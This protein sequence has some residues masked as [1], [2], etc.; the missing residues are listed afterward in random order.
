[1]KVELS[2]RPKNP[3]IIE[4]FP[5]FG[6]VGN[7]STEF[8][9][10]HLHAEQ[11]GSIKLEESS[12]MIA[13][14]SG[15]V[16][17]PIG[18]FYDKENNIVI[19]HVIASAQGIEWKMAEIISKLAEDLQARE[20]IC[21]EGVVGGE[22]GSSRSFYFSNKKSS[23]KK[24]EEIK[25]D[26]LK[27]GIVVGVTGALLLEKDLP[28]SSIF[29]ETHSAMPDSKAAA[30]AIEVLD[31]YLGLNVDY[32]PLLKQAQEFENKLKTLMAQKNTVADAQEKKRMSYIS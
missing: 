26:K 28:V 31:K 23:E 22:D 25:I 11:I 4:G 18:I 3:I 14:H 15:K 7:I 30:K 6:L 29:V 12:P 9:I 1:M 19:V 17:H 10:D 16:V 2:K 20:V 5:G 21:I 8:L 13:I 32:K 24:F 27:E